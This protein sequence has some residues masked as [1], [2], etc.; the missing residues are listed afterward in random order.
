MKTNID[1]N[2]LELEER[3]V[4]VNRVAKVVK[5]GRRF[6]FAALV[7]VGDKNGNVG[8]GTGKAQEVPEA[9][10]KAVDD[11]KKN[12][13]TVPIV[14]TTIPHTVNGKF[15]SGHVLMKPASEGT[16]VISG[17][18]VRAVLELA[19]IGDIL[20]KSL[21]SNT[22]INMIRA[23]LEGLT[24]LKRAE[25]VAKLRGKSVEELLG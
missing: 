14:G 18:P 25:D 9:I 4:T 13:I 23:T 19:G 21:G 22:P 11:A 6:R 1:P 8:F 3:V 20:T 10:K 17:G 7:V 15:G 12:L 24:Q 2:K 5:G 16:G